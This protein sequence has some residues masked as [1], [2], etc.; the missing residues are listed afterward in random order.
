[1]FE[2]SVTDLVT[3]RQPEHGETPIWEGGGKVKGGGVFNP[4]LPS[5]E[6]M[7]GKVGTEQRR[8]GRILTEPPSFY[9]L[10]NSFSGMASKDDF[11]LSCYN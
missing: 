3:F 7:V 9:L 6:D 5:G 2:L 1:M 8:K 11:N 4:L 10:F